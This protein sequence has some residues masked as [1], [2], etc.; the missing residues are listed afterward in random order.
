MGAIVVLQSTARFVVEWVDLEEAP[1]P[2]DGDVDAELVEAVRTR[3]A[4]VRSAIDAPDDAGD[5]DE[6]IGEPLF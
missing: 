1:D 2:D 4:T 3:I 6:M 5:P